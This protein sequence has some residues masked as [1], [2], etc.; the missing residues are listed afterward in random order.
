[1]AG[2]GNSLRASTGQRCGQTLCR[3]KRRRRA[4]VLISGSKT[5]IAQ[6]GTG[7]YTYELIR[8]FCKLP[9]GQSFGL[10]SGGGGGCAGPRLR[11]PAQGS[12]GRSLRPRWE[13][14]RR[15][16]APA[17]SPTRT[18]RKSSA[19]PSTPPIAPTRSQSLSRWKARYCW[20]LA[21][22]G[23]I[24][25]PEMLLTGW[26]IFSRGYPT[27]K[28]AKLPE[29]LNFETCWS[30]CRQLAP[31]A[32][33]CRITEYT[34]LLSGKSVEGRWDLSIPTDRS[35]ARILR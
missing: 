30:G 10:V 6:V 25:I 22:A 7:K 34:S 2:P 28:G 21:R 29:V 26:Q 35:C 9:A 4:F 23:S 17:R 20:S 12:P 1:V 33:F 11:V 5:V 31:A 27:P 19:T 14:P 13:V 8:D 18:G 15:L 3:G 24:R 16:G 32:R